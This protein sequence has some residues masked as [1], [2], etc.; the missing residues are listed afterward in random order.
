MTVKSG[1]SEGGLDF[2]IEVEGDDVDMINVGSEDNGVELEAFKAPDLESPSL[3]DEEEDLPSYLSDGDEPAFDPSGGDDDDDGD[4]AAKDDDDDDGESIPTGDALAEERAALAA[5][6]AQMRHAQIVSSAESDMK[7][8]RAH[9]DAAQMAVTTID[10]QVRQTREALAG[11]KEAGDVYKEIELQGTLEELRSAHTNVQNQLGQ[12][13]D[14]DMIRNRANHEISQIQRPQQRESTGGV[15]PLNGLAEKWSANN[16]WMA[17]ARF[18]KER[19]ALVKFNDALV[20]ENFDAN[21]PEFYSEISRRMARTYPQLRVKS[22][23]GRT[24]GVRKPAPNTGMNVA[25]PRSGA[26]RTATGTGQREKVSISSSDKQMAS[27]LGLDLSDRDVLAEFAS[28]KR[29][30]LKTEQSSRRR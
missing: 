8:A 2:D 30:R 27:A 11:S 14:D 28:N 25:N 13:P 16:P 3:P 6:R 10:A 17:D 15:Q 9:R 21:S 24:T 5:E 12:I 22:L 19:D 23:D 4:I 1:G 7:V 20:A 29:S 18:S 26:R